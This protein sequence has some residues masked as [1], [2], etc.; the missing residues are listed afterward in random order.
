MEKMIGI[1]AGMGPRSTAPFIDLVIDEC[2]KQYGA[3]NDEDFPQM[4]I[5]SLPTPF[6]VK[7]PINHEK[8]KEVLS[9]GLKKLEGIG[10]DFISM[11]CNTAHIYYEY[12]CESVKVPIINMIDECLRKIDKKCKN[13]S[14]LATVPTIKSEVYQKKLLAA[15]YNYVW[16][17]EFQ[18]RVND[19]ISKIK[20]G[21]PEKELS[22]E[23][24][25]LMK[26]LD[27]ESVDTAIIACTD[28]NV[29]AR[30]ED[31]IKIVDS[32]KILAE[33]TVKRY[34]EEEY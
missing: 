6:H 27:N 10:V 21:A 33:A 1:L 20:E 18:K 5:Y 22:V 25:E 19:I 24:D 13:V 28:L 3:K 15:G 2:Q 9:C 4:M 31:T 16:N 7:K 8:M 11:P 29:I 30:K 34:L 12:L 26:Q 14:V 23:W 32:A 17:H